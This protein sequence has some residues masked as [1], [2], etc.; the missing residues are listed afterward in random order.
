[1]LRGVRIAKKRHRAK[2]GRGKSVSLE[3][4]NFMHSMDVMIHGRQI[5]HGSV[6]RMSWGKARLGQLSEKN[7]CVFS[8][9]ALIFL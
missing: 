1:M 5:Q 4:P 3:R 2:M 7:I 6:G 8:R 9:S